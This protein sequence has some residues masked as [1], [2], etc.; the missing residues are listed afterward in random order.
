MDGQLAR[1]IELSLYHQWVRDVLNKLELYAPIGQRR[2]VLRKE[3]VW[4]TSV[5]WPDVWCGIKLRPYDDRLNTV[6]AFVL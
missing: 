1:E 3:R 2:H 6:T 5:G 4:L